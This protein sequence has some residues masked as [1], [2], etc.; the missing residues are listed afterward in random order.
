YI[1]GIA[2]GMSRAMNLTPFVQFPRSGLQLIAVQLYTKADRENAQKFME[3]FI[4]RGLLDP[5][6]RLIATEDFNYNQTFMNMTN[7]QKLG[8]SLI[9]ILDTSS[10][11]GMVKYLEKWEKALMPVN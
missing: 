11:S 5:A 4:Q 6:A 10:F 8:G 2:M 7:L 1:G 9:E 3:A